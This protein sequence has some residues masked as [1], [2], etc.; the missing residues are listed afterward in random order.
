MRLAIVI[1]DEPSTDSQLPI[2]VPR[3]SR[4]CGERTKTSSGPKRDDLDGA[5]TL[6]ESAEE[7]K[8]MLFRAS[9][10]RGHRSD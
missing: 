4:L 6:A 3:T 10:R 9:L 5:V 2:H 7:G 1:S 8:V